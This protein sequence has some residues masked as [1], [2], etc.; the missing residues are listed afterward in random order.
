MNIQTPLKYF[1]PTS[2]P[3][4]MTRPLRP[5]LCCCRVTNSKDIEDTVNIPIARQICPAR[6]GRF[7]QLVRSLTAHWPNIYCI[8]SGG[9]LWCM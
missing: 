6:S 3:Q 7:E 5:L 1:Q 9:D 4:P 2:Q 8:T